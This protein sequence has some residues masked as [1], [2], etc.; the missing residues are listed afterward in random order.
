MLAIME[1]T[2]RKHCTTKYSL[3]RRGR[4]MHNKGA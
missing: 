2:E 3:A 4:K 1:L